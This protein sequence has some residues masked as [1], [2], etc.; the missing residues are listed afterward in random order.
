VDAA[1]MVWRGRDCPLLISAET[2]HKNP[3]FRNDH[4]RA[5][6][7]MTAKQNALMAIRKQPATYSL[8]E[9]VD[10]LKSGYLNSLRTNFA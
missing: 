9:I 1:A 8:L 6:Q 7:P 3:L 5:A 2:F 10:R 4:P